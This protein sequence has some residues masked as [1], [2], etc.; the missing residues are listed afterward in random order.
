MMCAGGEGEKTYIV[1]YVVVSRYEDVLFIFFF[2]YEC[3]HRR[4]YIS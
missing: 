3:F 1:D 4:D 2:S